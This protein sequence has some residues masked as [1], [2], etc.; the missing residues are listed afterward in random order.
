MAAHQ[1]VPTIHGLLVL[2]ST[3]ANRELADRFRLQFAN[4]YPGGANDAYRALTT[5]DAAWP[6]SAVLWATVEGNVAQILDRPPRG[7]SLG[8]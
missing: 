5:A 1:Q 8:R 6:S 4:A 2:R 7:V 3:A